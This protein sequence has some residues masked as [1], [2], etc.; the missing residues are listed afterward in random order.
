MS[1][2]KPKP[3]A[4]EECK[5]NVE[6]A[7]KNVG[8]TFIMY[9]GAKLRERRKKALLNAFILSWVWL[10]RKSICKTGRNHS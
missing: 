4:T 1:Q 10:L 6:T 3:D 5:P 9:A 2:C 8:G 7:A